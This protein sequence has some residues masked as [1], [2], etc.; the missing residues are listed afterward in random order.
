MELGVITMTLSLCS[1]EG[2]RRWV[3]PDSSSLI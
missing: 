1:G 2:F 3:D